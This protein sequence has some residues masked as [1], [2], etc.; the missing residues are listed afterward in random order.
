MNNLSNLFD[1]AW[2]DALGWTLLHSL[3]QGAIIALVL[4]ISLLMLQ[5]KSANFRYLFGTFALTA[6]LISMAITFGI[7]YAPNAEIELNTLSEFQT[8][9]DTAPYENNLLV[10]ENGNTLA[11]NTSLSTVFKTYFEEHMPFIIL[12]YLIGVL[13][14]TMRMLG[15]LVYIQNLRH[16]RSQFVSDVWQQKL[17][18]L[19][20]EMG[21][22]IPVMLKESL[23]V[24]SP[25]VIGFL[26]P[27]VFVPLGLLTNLPSN[28]IES[29]LAHELAH[30]RRHDYLINLVQ[31]FVE[32]LLFFNPAVWWISSF[33][34]SE[35]EH[36]CDD[37]A[38]DITG[39][40]LTFAK[41]L[42]NL[43]EWRM[44]N[45]RLAVAFAGNRNSGVLKRIQR[46]LEKKESIQLPFRLFWG[47]VILTVGLIFAAF[48]VAD[49]SFSE[50]NYAPFPKTTDD[51]IQP[52]EE[53]ISRNIESL[54]KENATE[55]D[56]DFNSKI[57]VSPNGEIKH[58]SSDLAIKNSSNLSSPIDQSNNH[59]LQTNSPLQKDTVPPNIKNLEKE[60]RS[61]QQGFN[62]QREELIIQMKELQSKRYAIEKDV[63]KQSFEMQSVQL[64]LQ[65]EMQNIE[66]EKMNLE[67]ELNLQQNSQEK[68]I[69]ELEYKMQEIQLQL[70]MD[71][72]EL[73]ENENDEEIKKEI[74][75][76][77]KKIQEIKKDVLLQEKEIAQKELEI[78]KH[79]ML[80][81]KELQE[82][83]YNN[84]LLEH[85]SQMNAHSKDSD[86][87]QL[88]E[89]MQ[90]IEMQMSELEFKMQNKMHQLEQEMEKEYDKMQNDEY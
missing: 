68:I 37:I 55:T 27:I 32:I 74:A 41:T 17:T 49:N 42:A 56:S 59:Y 66:K 79:E 31:S 43:E 50:H 63:Q 51:L 33:I 65:R 70:E 13:I 20:I 76:K 71:Y 22:K 7:E 58:N 75:H 64:E 26:K 18:N 16:A 89:A 62:K 90:V 1:S 21:I 40:E 72:Q 3:W 9:L 80:I 84:Q 39:D 29:I 4:A 81:E 35:R 10:S 44:Q 78:Q 34:R 38:I 88:E 25:M 36:C 24:S 83:L 30:I 77:R 8:E 53:I 82:K 5:K 85:E 86:L 23:L 2:I 87:L 11:K 52:S 69:V 15:E 45:G 60:I 6:L 47:G 19:S 12:L 57:A 28:Q 61:I 73:S 46:L 67:Q 54:I 14:L 48:D